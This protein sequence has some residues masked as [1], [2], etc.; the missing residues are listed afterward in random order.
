MIDAFLKY[1]D[2]NSLFRPGEK[3]L[4]AV[5]G[6]IDSMVM[7]HLFITTGK[8]IA[9]VHC[10]F[11]LRG[12]ESDLDEEF[13]QQLALA[14][15]IPFY[16]E[17]FNTSEYA[18]LNHISVQVAARELR[19]NWFEKIRIEHGYDKIAVAHNLNDNTETLLLNLI[20][21]TGITGLTGM[22]PLSNRVIRPILFATREEVAGYADRHGVAFR[23]DTS[24]SET[25]YTRNKI[26]HL[27]LPLLRTLNPSVE[28]SINETAV[29]LSETEEIVKLFIG[30]LRSEL[31]TEK[32][33]HISLDIDKLKPWLHNRTILFEIFR[34]YGI[35]GPLV[36]D[37]I[38]IISGRT[39]GNI[40]TGK[41][42]ILKNRNEIIISGREASEAVSYNITGLMGFQEIPLVIS[43]EEVMVSTGFSIPSDASA[44]C[45]DSDE[46][47]YPVI[48]RKWRPGDYFYPLGMDHRKKISDFLVDNKYSLPDKENSLV[49]ECD[50]KIAWLVGKRIDNR[51]RIRKSTKRAL[52]ITVRI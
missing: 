47:L 44:G 34:P 16:S 13:V 9:L 20:R 28:S 30:R 43:A 24:N 4:L 8:D 29:R 40:F 50:G 7:S 49:M 12:R 33:N 25:K 5:S 38:T 23:E 15:K 27:V 35:T 6:G 52:I 18:S 36:K 11:S 2:T 37:L 31:F 39:G 48:I 10:N 21:G 46:V 1:A 14:K 19:Y 26:R 42:R 45:F 3:I 51:F 22:K 17:R 32:E 41:Y